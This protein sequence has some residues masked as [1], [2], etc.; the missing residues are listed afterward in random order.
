VRLL[1]AE[2]IEWRD[3]DA[4]VP[5]LLEVER[6]EKPRD[7]AR[8]VPAAVLRATWESRGAEPRPVGWLRDLLEW[9][10]RR[11]LREAPARRVLPLSRAAAVLGVPERTLRDQIARG[12]R[13]AVTLSGR[14]G[15]EVGLEVDVVAGPLR[16]R[17][18]RPLPDPRRAMV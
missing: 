9:K 12:V 18:P 4:G 2:G 7:V 16:V 15:G 14:R 6:D 3:G 1:G 8:T 13:E 5:A 11:A 10:V 17:L